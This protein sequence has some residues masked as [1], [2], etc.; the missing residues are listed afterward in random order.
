[1]ENF[2]IC[3]RAI[4]Q[5]KGKILI[6]QYKEKGYYFFPGGHLEFGEK[7]EKALSR[8]IKEELNLKIKKFSLIGL[9]DNIYKEDKQKHHEINL[10]FDVKVDKINLKSREDHIIFYFFDKIKFKRE[11]IF[12][13]ALQ[14]AIL[15]WIKDKKFF[16]AS[17]YYKKSFLMKNKT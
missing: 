5:N 17:Q 3:I 1:M 11:K 14:K 15:K 9:V 12:P 8:E 4:I 10:V 13:I 6:C 16:W 7:I 2:E